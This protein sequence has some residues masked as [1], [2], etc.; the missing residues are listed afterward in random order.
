M[1]R[2]GVL[3]E[4]VIEATRTLDVFEG[5]LSLVKT[6]IEVIFNQEDYQDKKAQVDLLLSSQTSLLFK[7]LVKGLTGRTKLQEFSTQNYLK[8]YL[9]ICLFTLGA[10]KSETENIK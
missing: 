2:L 9:D 6:L 7:L 3:F 5:L 8:E 4:N 1:Q 10:L